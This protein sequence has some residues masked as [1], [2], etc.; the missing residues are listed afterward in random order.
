[1]ENKREYWD[2]Q[3]KCPF[4]SYHAAGQ[5]CCEGA[6][7]GSALVNDFR[8]SREAERVRQELCADDYRA[9]RLYWM[10]S[11]KYTEKGELIEDRC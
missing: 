9:C 7:K 4:F 3:V 8:S 1:M 5:I 10:L 2:E 11:D 6:H